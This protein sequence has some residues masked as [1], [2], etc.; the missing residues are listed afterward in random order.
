MYYFT[1]FTIKIIILIL[2]FTSATGSKIRYPCCRINAFAGAVA[3]V[4]VVVKKYT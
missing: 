2:I 3:S 4:S 1:F